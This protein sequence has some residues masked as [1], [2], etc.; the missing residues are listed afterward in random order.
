MP[1]S[2]TDYV[3]LGLLA[4]GPKTGYAIKRVVDETI[5][6]FWS[7]SFGQLYPTLR[8]L[9]EQGLI[10][11]AGTGA[12][13]QVRYALTE[14]GRGRFSDW[15]SEPI[16]PTPPRQELLLK[17]FFGPLAP[18]GTLRAQLTAYRDAQAGALA[19]LN[20]L[21]AML[22]ATPP[23]EAGQAPYWRLTAS[24]GQH[25]VRALLAW[26]DEALAEI[27]RLERDPQG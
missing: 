18:P 27:D 20:G 7:E 15:F 25:V 9:R 8:R 11:E 21:T 6:H 22:N 3:I 2:R 16:L 10:E 14:A 4:G 5:R 13:G 12:R 19:G 17:L 26:A 23:E 1:A 24:L